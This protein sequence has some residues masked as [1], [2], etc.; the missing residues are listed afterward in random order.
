[1]RFHQ[2]VVIAGAGPVGC[3]TA[4][5]FAQRGARVLLLDPDPPSGAQRFAGEL[6][7]PAAR[8]ALAS[9]GLTDVPAM[10]DH[11]AVE[12]FAVFDPERRGPAL[13]RYGSTQGGTFA[14]PSFLGWLRDVAEGHPDIRFVRGARVEQVDG[15]LAIWSKGKGSSYAA[16]APLI[17]GAHGR[18][19]TLGGLEQR[20]QERLS[21]MAGLIVR[22]VELPHEGFGHV[23]LSRVG[24]ALVYRVA[25]DEIR[26]CL[27]VPTVWKRAQRRTQLLW[28][29]YGAVLPEPLASAVK[30]ELE[31]GRVAWA[32]NGM[33]SRTTYG[34]EG[35][36]LVGD[37]V[38][39]VH[40][41]TAIGMT[42]G[43][44][45]ALAL[46]ESPDLATYAARRASETR[47]PEL[48]ATALYEIFSVPGDATRACRDAIFR[49]W[50]TRPALRDRT[51]GL[52]ACEETRLHSLVGVG[53]EMV[54]RALARVARDRGAT[55]DHAPTWGTA[56]RMAGL[57]HWLLADAVPE[58]LQIPA[59]QRAATPFAMLRQEQQARLVAD[60][61][62]M[63]PA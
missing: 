55:L 9:I 35:H 48:L 51:M 19:G 14:F 20:P 22:D 1:M 18:H 23:F 58:S 41:M 38:G 50:E 25:P 2:D 5:A 61:A 36:A 43:F 47:V 30:A 57:I 27:D 15:Q 17:V 62:A 4:L 13:L 46:A 29:A 39:H 53:S 3:V 59:F 8:R 52:L 33:R 24:P 21:A 10:D 11:R 63:D 37:A 12:G 6:L 32:V 54:T 56:T 16:Y 45:D 60:L 28:D 40:P 7:H 34:R 42:L 31:A 26:I 49:M 44:G